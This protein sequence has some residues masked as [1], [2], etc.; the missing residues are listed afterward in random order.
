M[1]LAKMFNASTHPGQGGREIWAGRWIVW[2]IAD[3]IEGYRD[4]HVQLFC[5]SRT[6][7]ER[8]R[9]MRDSGFPGRPEPHDDT[10]YQYH[11]TKADGTFDNLELGMIRGCFQRLDGGP[12]RIEA[13]PAHAPSGNWVPLAVAP[14]SRYGG[15][16]TYSELCGYDLPFEVEGVYDLEDQVLERERATE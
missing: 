11:L 2:E 3:E 7:D 15:W 16:A 6:K 12:Y 4:V 10:F 8:K 9:I 14:L 5:T 1:T 13:E